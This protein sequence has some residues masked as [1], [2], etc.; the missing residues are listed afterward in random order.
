MTQ[1]KPNISI[2]L[3]AIAHAAAL[4]AL[5]RSMSGS[6]QAEALE[7]A[8]A[9]VRAQDAWRGGH[10]RQTRIASVRAGFMRARLDARL[11]AQTAKHT[12]DASIVAVCI[13]AGTI[14]CTAAACGIQI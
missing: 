9:A 10:R 2:E 1:N 6:S 11:D 5:K 13:V 14:I 7:A 12:A 8:R 3:E 4:P